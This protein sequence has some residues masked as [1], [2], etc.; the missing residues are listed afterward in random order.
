MY[1]Y[2]LDLTLETQESSYRGCMVKMVILRAGQPEI[3]RIANFDC[4]GADIYDPARRGWLEAIYLTDSKLGNLGFETIF[5]QACQSI[6]R[7]LR[8]VDNTLKV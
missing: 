4:G 1:D 6:D 3:G 7:W 5:E 8:G 2:P